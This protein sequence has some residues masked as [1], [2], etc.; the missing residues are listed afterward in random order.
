MNKEKEIIYMRESAL[1]SILSDT[2]LY[3][4]IMGLMYFNHKVLNGSTLID[5][6][7][8]FM[9]FTL[10]LGRQSKSIKRFTSY[11]ELQDYLATKGE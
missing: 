1:Q 8:I 7:F 6:V 3:G 2:F 9:A 11:K 4:G 10:I 5:V